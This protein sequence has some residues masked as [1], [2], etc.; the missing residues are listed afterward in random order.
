MDLGEPMYI[1][2]CWPRSQRS[3]R[4]PARVGWH[5]RRSGLARS[6]AAAIIGADTA[7]LSF[8][9]LA[10]VSKMG[11]A[12]GAAV[13]CLPATLPQSGGRGLSPKRRHRIARVRWQRRV[14]AI[15]FNWLQISELRRSSSTAEH[16]TCP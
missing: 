5:L 6:R 15:G 10:R 16:D 7:D 2:P 12:R 11:R 13:R 4:Q 14:H 9:I 3:I 1:Q 8:Q